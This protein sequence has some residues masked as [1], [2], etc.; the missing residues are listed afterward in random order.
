M[1]TRSKTN[2][3][4]IEGWHAVYFEISLNNM[5]DEEVM[6]M[7]LVVKEQFP[8]NPPPPRFDL[9]NPGKLF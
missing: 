6:K 4:H 8:V 9:Y 2:R 5:S 1:K 3:D 7:F